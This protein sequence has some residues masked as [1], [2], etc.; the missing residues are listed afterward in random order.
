MTPLKATKISGAVDVTD[1]TIWLS[2][3]Y[4]DCGFAVKRSLEQLVASKKISPLARANF[5]SSC[6]KMYSTMASKVLER[7]LQYSFVW[8]LQALDPSFAI[9]NKETAIENMRF[10][11]HKLIHRKWKEDSICDNIFN[12]FRELLLLLDK[13]YKV[14]CK[15]ASA[16]EKRLDSFHYSVSDLIEKH[17]L[18]NL[19]HM[20]KQ[21]SNE[22]SQLT[23]LFFNL[24]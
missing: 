6:L 7:S 16:E 17:A 14:E 20:A 1:K 10:L 23:V 22:A 4:V 3:D 13:D 2:I 5:L 21:L 19:Y 15:C 9:C 11:L 8:K 12:Q 24:T 18:K